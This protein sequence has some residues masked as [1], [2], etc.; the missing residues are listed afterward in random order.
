MTTLLQAYQRYRGDAP[1]QATLTLPFDRRQKSRLRATLDDGREVSV[2][3]DRGQSLQDGDKLET[4]QGVV[5]VV[6]A[7]AE[8]VSV[9]RSNDALLLSRAA[10]HLGNRHMPLQIQRGELRY[11]HD[12]VLDDMLRRLGLEPSCEQLP[13]KPESGA[14]GHGHQF[15]AH[16]HHGATHT[17]EPNEQVA[18]S[19]GHERADG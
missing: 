8:T 11:C 16:H 1:A 7:Q 19:E 14:Y 6:R 17:H 13:F 15:A 2:M 4:Q 18:R 12:H 9:V 5:I 3:L 10:Y